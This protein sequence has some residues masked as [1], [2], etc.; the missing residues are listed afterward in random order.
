MTI[1]LYSYGFTRCHTLTY[2]SNQFNC[3]HNLLLQLLQHNICVI[4]EQLYL[5]ITNYVLLTIDIVFSQQ[6]PLEQTSEHRLKTVKLLWLEMKKKRTN[7]NDHSNN[8]YLIFMI[9]NFYNL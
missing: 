9:Q 6:K 1:K 7:L 8:T 2:H 3:D 5:N 4:E